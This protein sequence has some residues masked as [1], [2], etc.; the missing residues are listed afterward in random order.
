[1]LPL[2]YA[3]QWNGLADLRGWPS[4]EVLPN[5][6]QL[7]AAD[8]IDPTLNEGAGNIHLWVRLKQGE[9]PRAF[10]LPYSKPLHQQIHAAR[11]KIEQGQQQIG[12]IRDSSLSSS[13]AAIDAGRTLVFEAEQQRRL[14]PKRTP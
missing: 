3:L 4:E 8:V 12:I 9:P 1:M 6:F 10:R 5:R 7:L 13:G 14:P 11:Q 2:F